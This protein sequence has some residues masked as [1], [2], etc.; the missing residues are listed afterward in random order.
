M[1]GMTSTTTIIIVMQEE[2]VCTSLPV[3]GGRLSNEYN[4]ANPIKKRTVIIF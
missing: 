2:I 1:T 3:N 4:A